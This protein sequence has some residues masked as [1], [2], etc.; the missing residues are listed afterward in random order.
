MRAENFA[1]TSKKTGSAGW[2]N[3]RNS[4]RLTGFPGQ[5][6]RWSDDSPAGIEARKKHLHESAAALKAIVARFFAA[7]GAA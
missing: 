7:R 2:W 5:N 6:R 1:L 3:I 4:Q